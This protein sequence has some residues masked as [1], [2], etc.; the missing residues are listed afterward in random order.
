MIIIRLYYK[1]ARKTYYIMIYSKINRI[2]ENTY[3][4][5]KDIIK[6]IL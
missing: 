2:I 5:V 4:I 1:L 6:Y 3:I